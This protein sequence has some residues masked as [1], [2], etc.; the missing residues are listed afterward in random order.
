M[1]EKP[2]VLVALSGGVDSSVAAALLV[3]QGYD[4]MAATL[5]TFCYAESEGSHPKQC[6]GLEGVEAARAVAADLGI[7]HTIWDVSEEFQRGVVDNFVAEYAAGRTPNPCVRCNA[8]VK[9]PLMLSRARQLGCTHLA[10]GH[11][12]RCGV[13]AGRHFLARG[14]DRQKDQA[15]FLWEIPPQVLPWLILPIG[16]FT[17]DEIRERAHACGLVNARKPESQEICFVPDGNYAAFLKRVLSSGHPGF[18]SG[19]IVTRDGT[20]V[21][22]HD[23]YLGYTVGQRKGL[24][25]GHGR[26]LYVTGID[27]PNNRVVVGPREELGCTSFIAINLNA[28]LDDFED[29]LEVD[30]QIR[31][32][33]RPVRGTFSRLDGNNRWQVDLKEPA[34]A[35]TPGQ[36]AVFFRN[37]RVLAGGII[38]EVA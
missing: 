5:K 17:K 14:R 18:T 4:V 7:P 28:F 9:I 38:A 12:A 6:C 30:V 24:G 23:G 15:Y 27:A 20:V 19:E 37:D 32:R 29:D 36:S 16:E 13:E 33:A 25:G 1:T 8:T 34:S 10:T 11:Y 31:H 35:V 3:E 2:R 26:R 21:G 22:R